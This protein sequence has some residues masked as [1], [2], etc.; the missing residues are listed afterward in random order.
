V[1][2]NPGNLFAGAEPLDAQR[3]PDVSQMRLPNGATATVSD[4]F[5]RTRLDKHFLNDVQDVIRFVDGR[6]QSGG[7]A[8]ATRSGKTIEGEFLGTGAES[9]A[10]RF[11]DD[12]VVKVKTS[13]GDIYEPPTDRFLAMQD[14]KNAPEAQAWARDH[15]LH[16]GETLLTVQGPDDAAFNSDLMVQPFYPSN[17]L[18]SLRTV[19]GHQGI[20]SQM[21]DVL[22]RNGHAAFDADEHGANLAVRRDRATMETNRTFFD[23]VIGEGDVS[24][25][26]PS[27]WRRYE[28]D[29]AWARQIAAE[30]AAE[31]RPMPPI[32]LP[33]RPGRP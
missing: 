4:E 21:D 22:H 13:S 28:V 33:P 17:Y 2:L 27:A 8:V 32:P 20:K 15:N 9:R 6:A 14:L 31:G 18:Q 3:Y 26:A 23:P 7:H 16:M 24:N 5:Q 30:R 29:P 12:L 1:P 25:N 11:G 19:P 10:Y